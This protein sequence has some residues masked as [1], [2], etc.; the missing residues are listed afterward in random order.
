MLL[1]LAEI[2]VPS[3]ENVKVVAPTNR[4]KI[5]IR[6]L[7]RSYYKQQAQRFGEARSFYH[8]SLLLSLLFFLIFIAAFISNTI[9]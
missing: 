6:A 4:Y 5:E 2:A 9:G 7:L 1:Y 8:T 3:R